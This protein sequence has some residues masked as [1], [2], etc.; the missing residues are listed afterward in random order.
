METLFN[1]ETGISNT[2]W[3]GIDAVQARLYE[4][5]SYYQFVVRSDRLGP[6]W[7]AYNEGLEERAESL[8]VLAR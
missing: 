2:M 4:A 1:V 8:I 6:I 5:C 3:S 7:S